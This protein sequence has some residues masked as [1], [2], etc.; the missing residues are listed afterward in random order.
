M[1]AMEDATENR[2]SNN[3]D[4][5]RQRTMQQIE[6]EL[7]QETGLENPKD[8]LLR[9]SSTTGFG[10]LLHAGRLSVPLQKD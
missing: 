7:T 2:K 6:A 1:V 3:N 9:L 5:N 8:E 10:P 4:L